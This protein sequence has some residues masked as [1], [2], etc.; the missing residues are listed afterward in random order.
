MGSMNKSI[1][2]VDST[3][4]GGPIA[5]ETY[6]NTDGDGLLRFTGTETCEVT[7]DGKLHQVKYVIMKNDLSDP[8]ANVREHVR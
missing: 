7:V 4:V 3:S 2:R 1:G 5:A 8:D 6:A